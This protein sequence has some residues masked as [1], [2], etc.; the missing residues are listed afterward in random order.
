VWEDNLVDY[1]GIVDGQR[2]YQGFLLTYTHA[3]QMML[4][5]R[6]TCAADAEHCYTDL[7]LRSYGTIYRVVMY[8]ANYNI[9]SFIFKHSA[10]N[11]DKAG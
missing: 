5:L 3:K 9:V 10:G 1:T 11:E 2:Y 8:D 7:H 4:L 6:M